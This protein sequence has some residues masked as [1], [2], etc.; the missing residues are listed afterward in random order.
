MRP[1]KLTLFDG[2]RNAS[3]R[4]RSAGDAHGWDDDYSFIR[5]GPPANLAI[6]AGGQL[7]I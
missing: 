4:K 7:T 3:R 5:I 6:A 2:Q 1:H